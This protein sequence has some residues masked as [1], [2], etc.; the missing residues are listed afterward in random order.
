MFDSFVSGLVQWA[1]L[2]AA[3]L[4][5]ECLVQA[6]N[7]VYLRLKR[8][9]QSWKGLTLDVLQKQE[10]AKSTE[11]HE[12]PSEI[13]CLLRNDLATHKTGRSSLESE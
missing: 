12:G 6:G 13:S 2:W 9:G 5:T 4:S 11:V 1:V 7:S 3:G 8:G 10:Y